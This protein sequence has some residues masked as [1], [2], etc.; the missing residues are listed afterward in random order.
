M[1][2]IARDHG[3]ARS[4]ASRVPYLRMLAALMLL[5]SGLAVAVPNAAAADPNCA[6]GNNICDISLFHT[7]A[8][9]VAPSTPAAFTVHTEVG[10]SN[11]GDFDIVASIVNLAGTTATFTSNGLTTKTIHHSPNA[12]D[13]NFGTVDVGA[14][15][16]SFQVKWYPKL[17]STNNLF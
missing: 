14:G 8:Y 6:D 15:T 12:I 2:S 11:G 4:R 7:V 3:P 9:T 16:G 5:V 17:H 1:R 13:F 10:A